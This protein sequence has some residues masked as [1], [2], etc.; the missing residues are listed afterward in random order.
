MFWIE[1]NYQRPD[2]PYCK[3]EFFGESLPVQRQIV[4]QGDEPQ[5]ELVEQN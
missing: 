5:P 1:K 3:F 2:C 4:A